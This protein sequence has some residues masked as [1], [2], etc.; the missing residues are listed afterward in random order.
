MQELRVIEKQYYQHLCDLMVE[1]IWALRASPNQFQ[2]HC[3]IA[4]IEVFEKLYQEKKD[5]ICL[6]GHVGNWEWCN[7]SYNTYH[8]NHLM[9]L[10]RPLKNDPFDA[11]FKHFRSRFGSRLVP[12][13]Q[14]ARVVNEPHTDPIVLAFI[15]DQSP[16]PEYAYW[17]EF[18]HQDTCFFNGYDKVARKKNYPVVLAYL[19]KIKRGTYEMKV[20]LLAE[21][22]SSMSENEITQLFTTRLEQIIEA[23][24]AHWLWS[25][26]RWKHHR[27]A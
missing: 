2:Q 15:A 3:R 4:D 17:T 16:V 26:R 23:S 25:H 6:L 18:L 7:L 20:E 11:F 8:L 27:P 12:M 13:Q 1:D 24:P 14:L 21:N 10:Y 9:A 5:F 22:T 19:Q